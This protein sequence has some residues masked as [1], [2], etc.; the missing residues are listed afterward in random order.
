MKT[1]IKISNVVDHSLFIDGIKT[2]LSDTP[3]IKIIGETSNAL[4][5][6]VLLRI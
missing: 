5:I 2:V 6:M 1:K 4:E 3:E